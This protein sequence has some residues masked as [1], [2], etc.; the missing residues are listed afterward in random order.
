MAERRMFARSVMVLGSY[1]ELSHSAQALYVALN[2][3]ADDDG[4]VGNFKVILRQCRCNQ[5]HLQ[6]LLE[7][8]LLLQFPSGVVAITH[9]LIHNQLRKDRYKPTVHQ[10]EF[11][12]LFVTKGTPYRFLQPGETGCQTVAC[13]ET[14]ESR[15]KENI[16]KI[17]KGNVK[18]VED[19]GGEGNTGNQILV[20]E[21]DPS[22][23]TDFERSVLDFY[24][25][26]CQ[27]MV[28]YLYLDEKLRE[29]I[30]TLEEIGWN[31]PTLEHA[32]QIAGNSQFLLGE[33]EDHWV[34]SLDWLCE[35]DNLRKVCA[36]K[37]QSYKKKVPMGC[38]GLGEAELEAIQKLF[39]EA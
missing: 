12:Q 16:G 17:N 3:L 35:D 22:S 8:G 34:C 30:R 25:K 15:K 27:G 37:Y 13:L 6:S 9:W 1:P 36:G 10:A 5:K 32:F 14:Q 19:M 21:K 18:E 24:I 20:P 26:Y 11:G 7:A 33:N 39:R 29:K 38:S 4:L 31:L 28:Q 23:I 2:M